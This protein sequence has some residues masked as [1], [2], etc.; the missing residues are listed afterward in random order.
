MLGVE[1]L[2]LG[3]GRGFGRQHSDQYYQGPSTSKVETI[4]NSKGK[5]QRYLCQLKGNLKEWEK[6]T[7]DPYILDFVSGYILELEKIPTQC[8]SCR[9][10]KFS[11]SE[12][13]AIDKE[14]D[15]LLS[16]GAIIKRNHEKNEFISNISCRPKI[17][18]TVRVPLNLKP[19][20]SLC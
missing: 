17:N 7:S 14:L 20:L 3:R 16:I 13:V 6:L 10:L 9:E 1:C 19:W 5:N 12:Q 15:R 4:P 2:F 8:C 18:G 11:K